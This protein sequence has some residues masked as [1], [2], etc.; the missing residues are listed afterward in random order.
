M[1]NEFT[2]FTLTKY[3]DSNHNNYI[4]TMVINKKPYK[5][6]F[7][8]KNI[9]I[10]K[11][12]SIGSGINREYIVCLIGEKEIHKITLYSIKKRTIHWECNFL[13]R[14]GLK[15][16]NKVVGSNYIIEKEHLS[17]TMFLIKKYI[18][19]CKNKQSL[20]RKNIYDT[21]LVI[22][23]TNAMMGKWGGYKNISL[24]QIRKGTTPKVIN[25]NSNNIKSIVSQ[26]G[27]L[28]NGKT[29][30]CAYKKQLNSL[31]KK[32]PGIRIIHSGIE[33]KNKF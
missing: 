19:E 15:F 31:I 29:N 1:S 17:L 20:I 13:C 18:D 30:Q 26:Y 11:I 33:L 10:I 16:Y 6:L 9:D 5:Y 25:I 14:V 28:Y 27:P 4:L 3:D 23:T 24:V 22:M 8:N 7:K 32:Y 12:Q 2:N 21:E